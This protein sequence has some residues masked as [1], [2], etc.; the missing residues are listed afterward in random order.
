MLHVSELPEPSTAAA[1][2]SIELSQRIRRA[3]AAAGGHIGFDEYMRMAL[4]EPGLGYYM[5]GAV[6]FG[7][8][9][10][11]VT[12]PEISP[13]FG[14][15]VARQC[16]QVLHETGGG[17]VEFGAGSGLLAANVLAA[18]YEAGTPP[19]RYSI[20]ELSPELRERQLRT[21]ERH[22]AA[23]LDRVEWISCPPEQPVRGV[24]IAN[25]IL[26]A[27]PVKMF[28]VAGGNLFE[29]RVRL[30]KQGFA[31]LDVPAAAALD[32]RIRECI[33]SDIISDD[34]DYVSEINIGIAP[35]ISDLARLMRH[36]VALL[37]DYG[38]PRVEYY[39]PQRSAGTLMCHF[40][41]RTHDDPFWFPGI[42]DITASVDFTGVAQAADECGLQVLGFA[43]QASFLLGCG[44]L[45]DAE[46][47]AADAD[48]EAR[49]RLA[50]ETK[51]LTLPTEM[52]ARFKVLALGSGYNG[53]LRG[54]Q[55]RDDRHRL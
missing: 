28:R 43:E 41:H 46:Y 11:F 3:I 32:A 45:E 10:D 30:E 34:A 35:W 7:R 54:F 44:L 40:R 55:F 48:E 18:L 25:E 20:L 27:F 17:V 13:L 8:G 39:H 50:H 23:Y 12:A 2:V 22:A 49:Q 51:V 16:Q 42:Q 33:A 38:Y 24:V 5:A 53:A 31:W 26:D 21:L 14:R 19:Q 15:C 1:A 37:V 4:Y 47:P 52:G 36:A 29:R 6:K 9:G